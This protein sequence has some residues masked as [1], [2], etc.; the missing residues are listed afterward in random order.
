MRAGGAGGT[1]GGTDGGTD[2]GADGGTAAAEHDS[3]DDHSVQS[4]IDH[5]IIDAMVSAA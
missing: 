3:A 1:A 5:L 2:G 4:D